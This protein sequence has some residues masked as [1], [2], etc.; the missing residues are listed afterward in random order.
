[1][2]R[3]LAL[4]PLALLAACHAVL[5]DPASLDRRPGDFVLA[6]TVYGPP[7]SAEE[8]LRLP[9]GLR[10]A[11]YVIEADALLRAALGRGSTN[12]VFPPPTRQ[13]T[14]SQMDRLWRLIRDSGLLE[15]GN[16]YQTE[17][18]EPATVDKPT[19]SFYVAY[20]GGRAYL[21]VP[22][23]RADPESIAAEQILDQLAAW[24]WIPD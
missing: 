22:L 24:S 2:L 19:A 11:R 9:R 15:P 16:S 5:P 1:M 4:L 17:D 13:L 6:A 8:T 7:A 3:S 21:L 14:V 18:I 10:P 23:D 12:A 20:S